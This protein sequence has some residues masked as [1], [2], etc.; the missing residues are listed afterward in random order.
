ME[1][2]TLRYSKRSFRYAKINFFLVCVFIVLTVLNP[3][4]GNK[5][6]SLLTGA[7]FCLL[8]TLSFSGIYFYHRGTNQFTKWKRRFSFFVHNGISIM[9]LLWFLALAAYF[10][11]IID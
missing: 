3:K 11:G 6:A 1:N 10:V 2:Y 5:I 9:I 7:I 8:T 4:G